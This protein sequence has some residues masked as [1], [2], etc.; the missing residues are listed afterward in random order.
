M[1]KFNT[2]H[3]KILPLPFKTRFPLPFCEQ[4]YVNLHVILTNIVIYYF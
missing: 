2:E 1:Q 4:Y 3:T